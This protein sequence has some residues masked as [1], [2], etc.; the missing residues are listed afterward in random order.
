M[1][2]AERDE[3]ARTAFLAEIAIIPPERLV[4]VDESGIDHALRKTHGWS[5]RGCVLFGERPG[6][7]KHQRTSILAALHHDGLKSPFAYDGYCNKD[8]VL[9]WVE[10]VLVPELKP[11]QIVIMDNAPFH[12]APAIRGAIEAAGC[13]LRF[14]P[15]Y[16]PDINPIE[17]W[18]APIKKLCAKL[19]PILIPQDAI[20]YALNKYSYQY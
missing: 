6:K 20:D 16:S 12:K 17:P 19:F 2:Y 13:T 4:Y 1:L 11:G 14:L 5:K 8:V 9:T 10:N 7:Y 18:W 3:A 15:T